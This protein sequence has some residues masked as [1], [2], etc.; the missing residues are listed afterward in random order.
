MTSSDRT[1]RTPP[2][3]RSDVSPFIAN[4]TAR[5]PI[6]PSTGPTSAAARPERTQGHSSGVAGMVAKRVRGP[7]ST[8]GWT[9]SHASAL[10]VTTMAT[11]GNCSSISRMSSC[12][13][14]V[15]CEALR[16]S[17]RCKP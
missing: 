8:S 12:A 14:R 6:S 7:S 10:K 1:T 16:S 2:P 5:S 3:P 15:D 11:L 13:A 4:S 17:S 9:A